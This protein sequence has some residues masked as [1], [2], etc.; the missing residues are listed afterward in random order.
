MQSFRDLSIKRKLPGSPEI[1]TSEEAIFDTDLLRGDEKVLVIADVDRFRKILFEMLERHGYDVHLGLDIRDGLSLFEIDR[2]NIDMV[3]IDLSMP[4]MSSEE[5]LGELLA[6]HPEVRV[7][8]VTGFT[9]D[10]TPWH[11]AKAVLNK[12]FKTYHL[13]RTVRQVLDAG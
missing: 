8:V 3:V 7:L 5:V 11:G 9:M 10:S 13:L 2:E 12:P 1:V 4:D 6:L